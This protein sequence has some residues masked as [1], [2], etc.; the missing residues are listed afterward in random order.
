MKKILALLFVIV[1]CFSAFAACDGS[2]ETKESKENTTETVG[3]YDETTADNEITTQ[4]VTLDNVPVVSET[5]AVEF[6]APVNEVV[7]DNEFCKIEFKGMRKDDILG[8]VL[9]VTLLN[10]TTDKI[11]TFTT[12]YLTVNGIQR[13]AIFYT[14]VSAGKTSN[15]EIS[16][17]DNAEEYIDMYT[18]VEI[19]FIAREKDDYS[20]EPLAQVV[21]NYYPYGKDQAKR[22]ERNV[23]ATDTVIVDNEDITVIAMGIEYDELWGYSVKMYIENK[24]DKNLVCEVEDASVN[25]IM[26]DP[27][28]LYT[29]GSGKIELNK[30][31]FY[32][33]IESDIKS[34]KDIEFTFR[35]YNA[36]DYSEDDLFNQKVKIY[37]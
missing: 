20:G 34:I 36:D 3:A 27:Y 4:N 25:S 16:F 31:T 17:F 33:L 18:D 30:M 7:L 15:K 21:Y 11:I 2:D 6:P 9:D 14:D 24:S 13:E 10:K 32:D 23:Q 37:P 22:Y 29:V 1:L 8:T 26:T 5:P 19:A 35:V 12:E 28:Y